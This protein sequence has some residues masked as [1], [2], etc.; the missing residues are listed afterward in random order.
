VI[1][2]A[3][4]A[5]APTFEEEFGGVTGIVLNNGDGS[6][7]IVG[8]SRDTVLVSAEASFSDTEQ[9]NVRVE[10][11]LLIVAHDCGEAS[12]CTVDYQLTIPE[13]MGS[14]VTTDG[15]NVSVS[16]V[17]GG[18][19]VTTESGDIFVRR[20]EGD[21]EASTASGLITGTQNRS[22]IASFTSQEGEI[23]VSF[24]D[25]ID[26]LRAETGEGDITAQLTGGP[27]ALEVETG[28]GSIDVK[29]EEDEDADHRAAIRTG[30]GDIKVFQN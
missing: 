30:K 11:G 20:I 7:S 9:F 24:D 6:V 5:A 23:S 21:I 10:D 28:S 17:K 13:S 15:G 4:S 27:Y 25:V 14:E 19:G 26:T 22:Q 29:V 8:T 16:D 2:A 18:V 3:C 12:S 1:S